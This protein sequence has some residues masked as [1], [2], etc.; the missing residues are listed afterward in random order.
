VT[1]RERLLATLLGEDVDRAP[2]VMLF[3]P[4][5]TTL[6]R[7]RTEGL[8]KPER[9]GAEFGFDPLW[10]NVPVNLGWCP[11][12]PQREILEDRGN[13]VI[14]RDWRGIILREPKDRASM[15]EW[16]EHPV[17]TRDDWERVKQ[18][19]FNPDDPARFPANWAEWCGQRQRGDVVVQLGYFPWGIFGTP[20]DLLGAEELLLL[21]YDDPDWVHDMMD[22]LTDLWIKVYEKVVRDVRVD[23][24]HI[25]EDMAGKQGSLISGQM[26]RRF[27]TPNYHKIRDFA[28]A[29]NI[30]IISVD[31]DGNCTDMIPWF[32]EAGVN[33]LWPFERQAGCDVAAIRERFPDLGMLGG[34][35]KRAISEGC[36]AMDE[37]F[38]VIQ[39]VIR[40]GRF[41]PSPDHLIPH[42]VSWP[43]MQYFCRRLKEVCYSTKPV[44]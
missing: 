24:I 35:N 34:F 3:G 26:F 19:R 31:T 1:P 13:D 38:A 7:W 44:P 39:R 8:E 18:E 12:W 23:W 36:Q 2:Y 28:R 29:H 41:V 33:V 27:M 14:V 32:Q 43:N 11:P 30:P 17:K 37:E 22:Y 40:R 15:P 9:W 16:L 5:G 20:R 6:E 42:D 10:A 4:W 25:W 21:F